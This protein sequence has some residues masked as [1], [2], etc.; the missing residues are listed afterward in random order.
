MEEMSLLG[1]Q[2]R[3]KSIEDR[4]SNA[5]EAL[6]AG[7]EARRKA[8]LHDISA[9]AKK[10]TKKE[11]EVPS[12]PQV[13]DGDHDLQSKLSDALE[14]I[15][16]RAVVGLRGLTEVP[17]PVEAVVVAV[18]QLVNC[19][20]SGLDSEPVPSPATW[21][22]ARRVLLK[23]GHFVSA[24]RK[25]PFALQRGQILDKEVAR[26]EQALDSLPSAGA[27]LSDVHEAALHL[28]L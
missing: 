4:R 11:A 5:V 20:Y 3:S 23:P 28:R 24:L 7:L 19:E 8:T 16:V 25:F 6:E 2:L 10:E 21:E 27:G 12:S 18:L 15:T 22:E 13:E 14:R 1:S 17:E 26:A 9:G